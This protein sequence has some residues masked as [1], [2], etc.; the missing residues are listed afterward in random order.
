MPKAEQRPYIGG[1]A[2]I[3]GVMMRSPLSFA[4]VVRRASGELLVRERPVERSAPKPRS[5]VLKWPFVRGVATLVEAIGLG[6]EA[7]RFSSEIY[8]RDHMDGGQPPSANAAKPRSL[9]GRTLQSLAF[10]VAALATHEPDPGQSPPASGAEPESGRRLLSGITLLF[11]IGLFVVLPQAAAALVNRAT[12]WSLDLR[13]P[14]FQA[15][16]GLFK[17]TIVV[18]YL[19]LIRRIPEIRRVFQYHGAE[20]KTISTYEANEAL[21]VGNARS[22]TTLHPR[23][24]T[25]FIVMVALVSILAFTAIAP[26]LPRLP[27]SGFVENLMLILLKLPFLLPIA[28]VTFEIQRVFA[29]HCSRGPLRALLW[30]GFLV[31]RIT[32]IEPD[33]SQLE[34]ALAALRT[35]LWREQAHGA[36]PPASTDRTF[37]DFDALS[38]DPGYGRAA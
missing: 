35:T 29:R 34:V 17:L 9:G 33:D 20:H 14:Y 19:L 2:V 25:T 28:A 27:V 32:T 22:K 31:Q 6:S 30:P 23:C 7:L 10:W 1:Q 13:S 26:L 21:V 8:E 15:L 36:A 18:G 11:A 16:T 5:P 24:G 38:A 3:E 4:I 37:L 12:G